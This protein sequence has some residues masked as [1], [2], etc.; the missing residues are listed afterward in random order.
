MF[1]E[2]L[3]A[4]DDKLKDSFTDHV[5]ASVDGIADLPMHI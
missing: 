2:L 4:N 5:V 3:E 1:H